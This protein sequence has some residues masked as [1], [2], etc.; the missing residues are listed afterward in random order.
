MPGKTAPKT[1]ERLAKRKVARPR[2]AK[3][4]TRREV[5]SLLRANQDLLRRCKVRRIGIFGSFVRNEQT[6]RSDV[7]F[8]V[9]FS[10]PNFDRFMELHEQLRK[11]SGRKVELVTPEGLSKYLKPFV[12]KEVRWHE[13]G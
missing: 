8:L 3:V 5:L 12:E 4:Q 9:D 1:P 10:E 6:A 11:L 2:R 7:D 13:V